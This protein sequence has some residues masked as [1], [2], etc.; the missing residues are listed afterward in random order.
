M[1][2]TYTLTHPLRSLAEKKL[3][4]DLSAPRSVN[5]LIEARLNAERRGEKV[6]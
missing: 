4:G 2:A 1:P 6:D 3:K 5:Q